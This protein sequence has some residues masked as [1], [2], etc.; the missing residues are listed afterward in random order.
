MIYFSS[1][2]CFRPDYSEIFTGASQVPHK[3]GQ[4]FVD[5]TG[6]LWIF[7]KTRGENF[8]VLGVFSAISAVLCVLCVKYF[9]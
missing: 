1:R 2:V 4:D 5:Q 7:E 3:N 9:S 6:R 8:A